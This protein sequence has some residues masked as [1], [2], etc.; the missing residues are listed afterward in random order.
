MN[1]QNILRTNRGARSVRNGAALLRYV[2]AIFFVTLAAITRLSLDSLL[3][4][5]VLPY[6]FFYVAVALTAWREGLRP[7]LFSSFLGLI[8]GIWLIVPP[9]H[10]FA[11]R[12]L[13]D[14]MEIA[15]YLFVTGTLTILITSL[16]KARAQAQSSMAMAMEKQR[17][18]ETEIRQR[19]ETE[20]ALRRSEALLEQ[21][22]KERTAKLQEMVDE[23]R[24]FSYAIIHDMRAP[25]RSMRGFADVIEEECGG[26]L[27]SPS[28]EYLGRI[29]AACSRMDRLIQDSL[30]YSKALLKILPLQPVDL[31][32]LVRE[33]C[34]TYS[35]LRPYQAG[36]HIEGPFPVVLGNEAALTQCLSILLGNAVK[37]VAPGVEP[38]IRVW[39]DQHDNW[40]TISVLDNGIG[41]PPSTQRHLFG[42]FQRHDLVHEGTGI[43][44]AIVRK[45]VQRMGGKVGVESEKGKGSRFWLELK[46]APSGQNSS[47]PLIAV[48]PGRTQGA[49]IIR[50][51]A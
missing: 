9:R 4:Q 48:A 8:L 16:C 23:L 26:A 27:P 40:A 47:E 39:A 31:S 5:E 51:P 12:S 35:N 24:H 37:F 50:C 20:A 30:N 34:T 25:L 19:M 44:L 2:S 28:R 49:E 42:I 36:I 18:L 6:S 14:I 38:K 15:V 41:I 3:G 13:A 33:L 22:V 1:V 7:A 45:L 21:R 17:E 11:L 46:L 29:R 32:K 10:S 43:G